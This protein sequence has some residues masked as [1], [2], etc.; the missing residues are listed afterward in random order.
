MQTSAKH[1]IHHHLKKAIPHGVHRAK[2]IFR[3]KYPKIAILLAFA[4]F[5][6]YIF[7]KPIVIDFITRL[8]GLSYPGVFLSG[9]FL[10]FGF[11]A[12]ISIGFLINLKIGSIILAALIGGSGAMIADLFI[13]K[14]IK[15][16]FMDELKELEKTKTIKKI[17]KIIENNRHIKIK[18]YLLYIFSGLMIASPLPDE[19]GVSVLAGLTTVKPLKLAVISFV[20]NTAVVFS[21]VYLGTKI[22]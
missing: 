14:T 3:F 1:Q 5:T 7:S 15:F 21:L 20:I 19:I 16:S 8:Q 13:F 22:F 11:T 17:E 6:Y 10:T 18:H 4:V 12:P 9:I 2:R